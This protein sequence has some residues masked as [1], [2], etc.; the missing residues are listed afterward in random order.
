MKNLKGVAMGRDETEDTH[1]ILALPV[2]DIINEPG[3]PD[4]LCVYILP[5]GTLRF[6]GTRARVKEFLEACSAAG[7]DLDIDHISRCG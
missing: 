4:R 5:N 1:L 6:K 3:E 2:E 7:L